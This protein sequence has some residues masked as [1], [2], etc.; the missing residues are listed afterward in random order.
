VKTSLA[1]VFP[2]VEQVANNKKSATIIAVECKK[3]GGDLQSMMEG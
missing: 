3:S 1:F 2:D